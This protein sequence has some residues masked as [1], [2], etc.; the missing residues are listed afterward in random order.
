MP[1]SKSLASYADIPQVLDPIVQAGGG[2][3]R[4]PTARMATAWRQRAYYYRT[5][6][7]KE[8]L[9]TTNL[10]NYSPPTPYDTLTIFQDEALLRIVLGVKI[11]GEITLADGTVHVPS[12]SM[13]AEPESDDPIMREAMN[14]M[15]LRS[16]E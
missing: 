7:R 1:L 6:L 14:L 2:T 15:N 16:D 12:S 8:L 3:Y 5:L 10:K 13:P 11:E 9:R 4:L